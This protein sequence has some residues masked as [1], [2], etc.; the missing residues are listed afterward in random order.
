MDA[1]RFS[2]FELDRE[3]EELTRAGRRVAI[4]HQAFVV[5]WILASRAGAVVTRD[6]LRR[7]LWGDGTHVD[8]DRSLNFCIASV[9]RAL[10]DD[11]RSPRFVE[12][13]PK[14]GYRFIAEVR[15]IE[16]DLDATVAAPSGRAN[17]LS[18]SRPPSRLPWAAA[19]AVI[20]LQA[21][22]VIGAHTRA[23]TAPEALSAFERGDYE[24]A[25]RRD[26]RFAEAHYALAAR[27]LDLGEQ[28]AIPQRGALEIARAAAGRAVALEEAPESR[29]LLGSLKLIVDWD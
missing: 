7:A 29:R 16:S 12:T 17:A 26:A 11:A 18:E 6:E 3:S 2:V 5:L 21:P 24:E 13:I 28:R 25:L 23:T 20:V 10:G 9:R 27:Y 1:L 19:L 8:F 4:A 15:A 14:C 22:G